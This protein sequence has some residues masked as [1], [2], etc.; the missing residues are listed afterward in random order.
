MRYISHFEKEEEKIEHQGRMEPGS[1]S[2]T[3]NA[4]GDGNIEGFPEESL[5]PCHYFDYIYGTSTGG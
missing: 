1:S 5:L 2:S 3:H 4:T